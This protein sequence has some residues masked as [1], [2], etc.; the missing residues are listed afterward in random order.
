[1]E[2]KNGN[3]NFW[4]SY[5]DLMAGLLFVFILLIGAIIVKY[6]L[7]QSES[8][9][10]EKNLE[11]EHLALMQRDERIKRIVD[12]L[13]DTRKNLKNRLLKNEKLQLTLD[14]KSSLINK[15][16]NDLDEKEKSINTF[17]MTNKELKEKI[18]GLDDKKKELL[19]NI[20][21]LDTEL[22]NKNEK[23]TLF[24]K[25]NSDFKNQLNQASLEKEHLEL[26]LEKLDNLS[27]DKEAKL[28]KLL[29]DLL[30]KE[31]M[32][33]SFKEKN[34]D[35]NKQLVA[36]EKEILQSK[37]QNQA[38]S[39]ES[40]EYKDRLDSLTKAS[41]QKESELNKLIE[42]LLVKKNLIESFKEKNRLLDDEM[43]VMQ[44]K[45]ANSEKK[46]IQLTSELSNTK[47]KI[48][49]F[50]G[51]KVK[52]ISHLKSKLGNSIEIDPRNGSLRLSANVLFDEGKY[53]LKANAKK[54]LKV[55]VYDYFQTILDNEEINRHIDKIVIEGHT[56]SKG[57][58]LYNLQLSQKRAYSVMDFL[59][60]LD[61]NK[62]ENLK[63]LIA[64]SGRSFLDP[65][66]D[67]NGKEDPEASR[68]I[69]IKLSLKNE[70]AIKEIANL[71]E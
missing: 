44:Q 58:Y 2:S 66:Y 27:K 7:L 5:A 69:E 22:K 4:I 14:Q 51:I 63:E 52:V 45:L 6:S 32:I 24:T 36:N 62:Q 33:D 59:L 26:N 30:L 64:A 16:K 3:T 15:Q 48:K 37:E 50:T 21:K 29:E 40:E 55:A 1:M 57:N 9:Q 68:R 60:T 13:E 70:Q 71:L 8:E 20:S 61:F 25:E 49:S 35:L 23:I 67:E 10:L 17:L 43:K 41:E 18:Q 31:Q 42:D 34:S 56:N 12:D 11:K 47:E 53:V 28:N 19:E 54:A 46:E 65:I 39:K 38:L